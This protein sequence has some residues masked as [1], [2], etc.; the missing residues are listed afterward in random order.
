MNTRT[1]QQLAAVMV[2]VTVAAAGCAGGQPG[3]AGGTTDG[4]QAGV[5]GPYGAPRA[6]TAQTDLGRQI[7]AF[8][9]GLDGVGPGTVPPAPGTVGAAAGGGGA[10]APL[11]I[12]G[13]GGMGDPNRGTA[14]AADAGV[15]P[16]STR[17][18]TVGVS[19]LVVA[20]VAYIGIDEASLAGNRAGVTP[21]GTSGI[22]AGPYGTDA[23][24]GGGAPGGGAAGA[25]GATGGTPGAGGG[26][27]AGDTTGAGNAQA[28][29]A[30]GGPAALSSAVM[31]DQ[32]RTRVRAA[33]PQ[34][35]EVI[36][37]TDPVM[38]YRIARVAGDTQ[39]GVSAA[40]HLPEVV[41]IMQSMAPR[42]GGS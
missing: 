17:P 9:A 37:T 20:N 11:G 2:S 33:F 1:R 42:A 28:G 35:V 12:N 5:T 22:T 15:M 24:A 16:G 25:G 26:P 38:V 13:V 8:V 21:G 39:N 34:I 18:A 32:I 29:G 23:A 31:E 14:G 30:I 36:V 4:V 6:N 40:T 3:G 27:A 19:T 7:S 41:G 10:R